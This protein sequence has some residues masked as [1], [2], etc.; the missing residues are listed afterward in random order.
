LGGI[1][2]FLDG[3]TLLGVALLLGPVTALLLGVAFLVD[4]WTLLGVPSL[5]F[6]VAAMLGGA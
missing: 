5:M 1:A 6:A 2:A 3:W 4:R